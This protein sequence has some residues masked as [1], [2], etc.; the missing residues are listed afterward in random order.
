MAVLAEKNIKS[1]IQH[2]HDTE[3]NW[4]KAENFIPLI[5]EIVVYDVDASN[6]VPRFKIGDG[7]RNINNLNFAS[8]SQ[9]YKQ[10]DQ[11]INAPEGALWID[12][13]QESVSGGGSM[14]SV[15]DAPEGAFL[16]IVNGAATW[17]S[18]PNAEEASF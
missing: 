11:P 15:S 10:N 17:V 18:L 4:I 16:R 7:I 14:P 1:R 13:D 3:T 12:L 9:I 8:E 2:K 6:S 5:G